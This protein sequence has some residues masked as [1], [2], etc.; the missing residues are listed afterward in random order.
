MAYGG[1][2]T[3]SRLIEAYTKG[4]FPWYENDSSPVLWWSPDPRALINIANFKPSRSL[5][6]KIKRNY[7]DFSIDAVFND[8]VIGCQTTPR[9]GSNDT[10]I[11]PEMR[12]AYCKLHDQGYAHSVES[13]FKGE[14]VGGLYGVS[15]GNWFFGESMFSQVSDASKAALNI[16]ISQ[17][18][19]WDF[20]WID[21]QIM[22]PHLDSL[23]A[24]NIRRAE[25]LDLLAQNKIST[26]RKHRWNLTQDVSNE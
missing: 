6:K 14:L 4:I 1:K 23:G 10:W 12:L 9:N 18:R 16:L 19:A 15:L 5:R 24:I 20:E 22:N 3:T 2:L 25:Y 11:T 17:L 13:W 21:C 7:F 26:T 8:V